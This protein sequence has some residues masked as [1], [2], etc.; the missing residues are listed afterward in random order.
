MARSTSNQKEHLLKGLNCDIVSLQEVALPPSKW[1]STQAALKYFGGTITFS[2]V[3]EADRRRRGPTW[4]VRLGC[5]LALAAVAPWTIHS[6]DGY[7]THDD[8]AEMVKHRLLSGVAACGSQRVVVHAV[9][10][11]PQ[12]ADALDATIFE[13][14][15]QRIARLGTHG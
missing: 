11:D 6:L 15:S 5:G 2:R 14:L 8:K 7:W 9:Y 3:R 13:V 12:R 10:L 1:P 4:G